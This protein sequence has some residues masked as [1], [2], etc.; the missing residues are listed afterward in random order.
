M[1]TTQIQGYLDSWGQEFVKRARLNL[2][3][4]KKGGGFLEKSLSFNVEID[5][6][7]FVVEL[8]MANYGS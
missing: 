8:M 5:P 4:G 2:K 1:R 3:K 6:D 7:G